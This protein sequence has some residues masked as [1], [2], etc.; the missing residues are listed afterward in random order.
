MALRV[1]LRKQGDFLFKNRSYLPLIIIVFGLGVY[2]YN[3]YNHD[4]LMNRQVEV[5]HLICLAVC[6]LGF[7]IRVHAVGFSA[8]N[9]SGRNTVV[10][11][12]ADTVNKTGMY[13]ICRHPL[14]IGNFF[15]WLGIAG[16]TQ[17]PWFIFA[18]IFIYWMYYERIMYAEEEFLI[19]KYGDEYV[20]WAKNTPAIFPKFS[21]WKKSEHAFNWTKVIRQEK[22]GLLN[23]FLVTFVFML[24]ESYMQ[25][26]EPFKMDLYWIIAFA[27]SIL[28]YIVIKTIQ[29]TTNLLVD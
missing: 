6:L 21:Q 2:I 7:F 14:Y 16:F 11:Q 18:F 27:A 4:V 29:K 9:T 10:G 28:W 5:Y 19:D 23:L 1:E 8:K 24:I 3:E 25:F 15:M 26:G 22:A 17:E 12:V 13:S 20:N